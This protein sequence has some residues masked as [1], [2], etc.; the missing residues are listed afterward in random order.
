ME[1]YKFSVP[2]KVN[3]IA[4]ES[5]ISIENFDDL[6]E[7]QEKYSADLEFIVDEFEY[8]VDMEKDKDMDEDEDYFGMSEDD[9][10]ND[11]ISENWNKI[12]KK[13][14]KEFKLD[15]LE[16][17]EVEKLFMI[18]K[19]DFEKNVIIK[20]LKINDYKINS[21][22]LNSFNKTKSEFYVNVESEEKL[23]KEEIDIIRNWIEV[24]TSENWGE[25][26]SKI[27]LSDKLRKEDTYV[28]LIP[29]SLKKDVK[30]IK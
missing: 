5:T 2:V 28:Y 7:V 9:I 4:D 14:N 6:E 21:I 11:I 13:L 22:V 23:F 1:N 20:E 12:V 27:D 30:Y 3:Y 26:F 16:T 17:E 8:K 29:W 10:F 19:E 18:T 15:D 24:Q 25:D